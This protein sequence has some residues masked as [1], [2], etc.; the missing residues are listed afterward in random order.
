MKQVSVYASTHELI[1][2]NAKK[3][4]ITMISYLNIIIKKGIETNEI[5]NAKTNGDDKQFK[6]CG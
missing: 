1:K 4:N 3:H 6:N 5:R 2:K